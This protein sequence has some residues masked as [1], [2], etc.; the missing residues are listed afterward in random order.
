MAIC[1][2]K[3]IDKVIMTRDG[4]ADNADDDRDELDDAEDNVDIVLSL[5]L[6]L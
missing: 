4:H 6:L 1:N 2:W 5:I 3:F